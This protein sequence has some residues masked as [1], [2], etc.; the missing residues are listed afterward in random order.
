[1]PSVKRNKLGKKPECRV[2]DITVL[3]LLPK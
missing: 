2:V 3:V 1:M